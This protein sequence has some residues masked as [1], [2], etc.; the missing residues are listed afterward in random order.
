MSRALGKDGLAR[1]THGAGGSPETFPPGRA[2]CATHT[3]YESRR[4]AVDGQVWVPP[5]PFQRALFLQR[6]TPTLYRQ[7]T[8]TGTLGKSAGAREGAR[9]RRKNA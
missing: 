4:D 1:D 2:N 9:G 5:P 6:H 7:T 3:H 8:G